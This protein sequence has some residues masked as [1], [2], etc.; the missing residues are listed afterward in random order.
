MIASLTRKSSSIFLSTVLVVG[1]IAV[2]SP[3]FI[4]GSHAQQEYGMHNN[5][6]D[7]KVVVEKLR[8]HNDNYNIDVTNS[9]LANELQTLLKQAQSGDNTEKY[10]LDDNII[11]ICSNVNNDLKFPVAGEP[12][13]NLQAPTSERQNNLQPLPSTEQKLVAC[14]D[15][16]EKLSSDL[17]RQLITS[18]SNSQ[19]P[20]ITKGDVTFDFTYIT[21][22][23]TISDLCLIID[24]AVKANGPVSITDIISIFNDILPGLDD[25]GQSQVADVIICLLQAG[26]VEFDAEINM[27]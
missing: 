2:S 7:P 4:I 25:K 11:L 5:Y 15:C 17:Q 1:M 14:D 22:T 6:K 24:A 3:S 9:E 8:C 20:I 13:S 18:I 23:S 27:N 16:L 26:I 12:V 21:E 10:V 19:N